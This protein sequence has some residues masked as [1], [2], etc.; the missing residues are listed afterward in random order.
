MSLP[1]SPESTDNILSNLAAGKKNTLQTLFAQRPDWD[2]RFC[3]FKL[4]T[5]AH[6]V[7]YTPLF[8]KQVLKAL[9]RSK[10]NAESVATQ[11]G[12][13]DG[14]VAVIE[15]LRAQVRPYDRQLRFQHV[16]L[17]K[18]VEANGDAWQQ[19]L[20]DEKGWRELS[21]A[22]GVEKAG[23]FSTKGMLSEKAKTFLAAQDDQQLKYLLDR[24][25]SQHASILNLLTVHGRELNEQL[26]KEIAASK[27][28]WEKQLK[29]I[30]WMN[31]KG[32]IDAQWKPTPLAQ[33][34]RLLRAEILR[35]QEIRD[36]DLKIEAALRETPGSV[37][38]DVPAHILNA[39]IL[40]LQASG[41]LDENLKPSTE[42]TKIADEHR[43]LRARSVEPSWVL[44]KRRPGLSE[45]SE[46]H[47]NILLTLA[48]ESPYLSEEQ[49]KRHFNV[50]GSE[51]QTLVKGSLLQTQSAAIGRR[52]VV[53]FAL[54]NRG[55][56]AL[57][58]EAGI[59]KP[60]RGK[61]QRGSHMKH[62][63]MLW[64]TLQLVRHKQ[65]LAR[66]AVHSIVHERAV[67]QAKTSAND[68]KGITTPDLIVRTQ[69]GGEFALEYGN[70]TPEKMVHKVLNFPQ[71]NVVVYSSS[72]SL[73][74]QYISLFNETCS[75]SGV[76][77]NVTWH[78]I[79]EIRL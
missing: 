47:K 49:I 38:L 63:F 48:T 20:L 30:E 72:S 15:A 68:N 9:D 58:C 31:T 13:I 26:Y 37:S 70:Y 3:F 60:L 2:E 74:D 34:I 14:G 21:Y 17:L 28:P 76:S 42:F 51:I 12:L 32:M 62:D 46:N 44:D 5:P 27:V 45:L 65:I 8:D 22:I 16:A 10:H 25:T 39:R 43:D 36:L 50:H 55:A 56:K 29:S 69:S 53:V 75:S 6:L 41:F 73:L 24:F 77:K 4:Y 23:W 35:P 7:P 66:D 78:Y 33:K 19:R 40:R 11:C 18:F 57:L 59:D 54:N 79:P 52:S 61:F 71:Q 64:E 67:Y 1:E